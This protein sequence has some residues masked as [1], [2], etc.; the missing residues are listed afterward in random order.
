MIGVIR[1]VGNETV[2]D[3][4]PVMGCGVSGKLH[5]GVS[6]WLGAESTV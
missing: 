3:T 2:V 4:E 1:A 6:D 5:C